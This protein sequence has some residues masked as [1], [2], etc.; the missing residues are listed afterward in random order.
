MFGAAQAAGLHPGN[1]S[2]TNRM[3]TFDHSTHIAHAG[4]AGDQEWT[5]SIRES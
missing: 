1:F 2:T 3:C 4:I 5:L